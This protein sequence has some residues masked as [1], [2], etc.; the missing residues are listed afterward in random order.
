MIKDRSRVWKKQN[1][2]IRF[3]KKNNES[4]NFYIFYKRGLLGIKLNNKKQFDNWGTG[5]RK[6][7]GEL[8]NQEH[9][10]YKNF[11]NDILEPLFFEAW[12]R[13]DEDYFPF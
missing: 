12:Q 11:Y 5:S 3:R 13:R 4:D 8:F 6:Y 10:K 7:I 9:K 2:W 1:W